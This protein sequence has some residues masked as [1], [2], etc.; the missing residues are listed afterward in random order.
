[1]RLMP[2]ADHFGANLVRARLDGADLQGAKL[3]IANMNGA[4]LV[5]STFHHTTTMTNDGNDL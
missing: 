1:M 3:H 2:K 5:A 4:D